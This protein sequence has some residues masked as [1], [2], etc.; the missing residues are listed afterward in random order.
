MSQKKLSHLGIEE[1]LVKRRKKSSNVRKQLQYKTHF[2]KAVQTFWI[3]FQ[4]QFLLGLMS[5]TFLKHRD[6]TL[7]KRMLKTLGSYLHCSNDE[8]LEVNV[9]NRWLDHFTRVHGFVVGVCH[10]KIHPEYFKVQQNLTEIVACIAFQPFVDFILWCFEFSCDLLNQFIRFLV[11]CNSNGL[12]KLQVFFHTSNVFFPQKC[13][14]T[15][16]ASR[17]NVLGFILMEK[18]LVW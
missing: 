16:L 15:H 5:S 3:V 12:Q 6:G 2:E 7:W 14:A 1:F 13:W 18:L 8:T 4:Q 9:D 11:L 10:A 17:A